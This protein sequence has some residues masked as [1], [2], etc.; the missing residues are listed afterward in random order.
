MLSSGSIKH[1]PDPDERAARD[2]SRARPGGQAFIGEMNRLAPPAAI[3]AQ[4]VRLRHWLFRFIYPRVFTKAMSPEEARTLCSPP[5]RS[6]LPV[7]ETDAAR[8]RLLAVQGAQ[9]VS[10]ERIAA[11]NISERSVRVQRPSCYGNS[12]MAG[13]LLDATALAEELNRSCHC[14]AVD[15]V[16]LRQRLESGPITAGVYASIRSNQPHLFSSSPVFLAYAH[17]EHM[18]R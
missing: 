16:K 13:P 6:A 12:V 10:A 3:A 7:E 4:R 15:Q 11:A 14:V 1:W 2:P 9:G 18:R 8:R 5:R 17:V